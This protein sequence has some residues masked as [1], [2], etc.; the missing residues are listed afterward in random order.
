MYGAVKNWRKNRTRY[1]AAKIRRKSKK[2]QGT[3]K[4]RQKNPPLLFALLTAKFRID[5]SLFF[6]YVHGKKCGLFDSAVQLKFEGG[7]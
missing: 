1:F 2:K 7:D 4:K 5:S 3:G 6:P